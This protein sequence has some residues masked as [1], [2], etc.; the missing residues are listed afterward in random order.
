MKRSITPGVSRIIDTTARSAIATPVTSLP[1]DS[2]ARFRS[3]QTDFGG[4][5]NAVRDSAG[6]RAI[7]LR[8]GPVCPTLVMP[9][10]GRIGAPDGKESPLTHHAPAAQAATPAG[11]VPVSGEHDSSSLLS[12]VLAS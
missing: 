2:A 7:I 5:G 3:A 8:P 9:A 6:T 10:P 1:A 11:F 12:A 4:N